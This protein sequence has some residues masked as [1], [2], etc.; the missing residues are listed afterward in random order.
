[1]I[2]YYVEITLADGKIWTL[3]KRQERA[4]AFKDLAKAMATAPENSVLRI[5]ETVISNPPRTK[6]K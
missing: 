6:T 5:R 2:R 1:M 3:D 4:D